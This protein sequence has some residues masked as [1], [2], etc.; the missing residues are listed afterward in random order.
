MHPD[1]PL[2]ASLPS[3]RSQ[4]HV[5]ARRRVAA[6]LAAALAVVGA[7]AAVVTSDAAAQR[8]DGYDVGVDDEFD[9]D[10]EDGEDPDADAPSYDDYDVGAEY[11]G[12]LGY[13]C[14]TPTEADCLD[15]VYQQGIC[16]A[17]LTPELCGWAVG[18]ALSGEPTTR[19]GITAN[20]G[21]RS[22]WASSLVDEPTS[23]DFDYSYGPSFLADLGRY[24]AELRN[25]ALGTWASSKVPAITRRAEWEANGNQVASCEEL[26]YEGW[27]SYSRFEDEAARRGTDARAIFDA[28]RATGFGTTSVRTRGGEPAWIGRSTA[29]LPALPFPSEKIPKNAYFLFEPTAFDAE[30]FEAWMIPPAE[31]RAYYDGDWA[32]HMEMDDYFRGWGYGAVA[33][34]I[35][36]EAHARQQKFLKLLAQ[37]ARILE[38]LRAEAELVP[39]DPTAV[40]TEPA[41]TIGFTPSTA[42][43]ALAVVDDIAAMSPAA[44]TAAIEA[45]TAI[46]PDEFTMFTGG[47]SG[48]MAKLWIVNQRIRAELEWAGT[49]GHLGVGYPS[50]A[51]WSPRILADLIGERY[52]KQREEEYQ[53]CLQLTGNDFS[54]SSPIGNPVAFGLPD[55]NYRG[56]SNMV[57]A[58]LNDFET[59]LETLD[60]T[61][62]PGA[63]ANPAVGWW[64]TGGRW[65]GNGTFGAG[66]D[67]NFGFGLVKAEGEGEC[68]V[69]FKVAAKASASATVAGMN[70]SLL[71]SDTYGI[72]EASDRFR[73]HSHTTLLGRFSLYTPI[74]HPYTAPEPITPVHLA[75]DWSASALFWI[76]PVPVTAEIGVAGQAGINVEPRVEMDRRCHSTPTVRFITGLTATPYVQASAFI[77]ALVGAKG[78]GAGLRTDLQL[79]KVS[80][81]LSITGVIAGIGAT[82]EELVAKTTATVHVNL[83]LTVDSLGGSVTGVIETPIKNWKKTLFA[84]EGKRLVDE[85]WERSWNLPLAFLKTSL[86]L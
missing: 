65:L 70:V 25:S 42:F 45:E 74:D 73:V 44:V 33:D 29:R 53:R 66:Y 28:A 56:H 79:A 12:W 59:Y 2:P 3:L 16:A 57:R 62:E 17:E 27:Y 46:T 72:T 63:P 68:A 86:G 54:D 60:F 50:S 55:R 18:S 32:W 81:P 51:D 40:F 36:Y 4:P 64:R 9:Y 24:S 21:G 39:L 52:V 71:D 67:Y 83:G 34:D 78:L 8:Y 43:G 82:V 38:K 22:M 35:M 11:G 19:D 75:Q 77:G 10:V 23:G 84:W 49:N 26:A 80:A 85:Q 76:G 5:A 30:M 7:G 1:R 15:P 47:Y 41:Y 58:F 6:R 37:R 31:G 69:N 14:P 48:T 13:A 61:P 20:E